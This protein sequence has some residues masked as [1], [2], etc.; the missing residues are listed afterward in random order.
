MAT[1]LDPAEDQN[2]LTYYD[3]QELV[4]LNVVQ[5]IEPQVLNPEQLRQTNLRDVQQLGKVA[6][7]SDNKLLQTDTPILEY[8]LSSPQGSFH[9]KQYL[10]CTKNSD[11]LVVSLSTPGDNWHNITDVVKT[12]ENSLHFKE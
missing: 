6:I 2:N 1:S 7:I 10:H 12:L 8:T 3:L 11:T 5:K 9:I 4:V